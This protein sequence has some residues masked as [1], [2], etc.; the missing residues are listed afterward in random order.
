MNEMKGM[1]K[2]E[3]KEEL[4]TIR[5]QINKGFF[6]TSELLYEEELIREI[7]KR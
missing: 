6:G 7:N 4:S 2:I 3:L 5:I 1:S